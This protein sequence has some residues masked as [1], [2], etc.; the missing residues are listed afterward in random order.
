MK[1][2]AKNEEYREAAQ[3]TSDWFKADSKYKKRPLVKGRRIGQ[4]TRQMVRKIMKAK[5]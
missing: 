5:S 2:A 4:S 3:N 1:I